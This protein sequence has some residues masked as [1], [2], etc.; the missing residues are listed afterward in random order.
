M[1]ASW[2]LSGPASLWHVWPHWVRLGVCVCDKCPGTHPNAVV[3]VLQCCSAAPNRPKERTWWLRHTQT[4]TRA[5]YNRIGSNFDR[6]WCL[7][8]R[9]AC[10]DRSANDSPEDLLTGRLRTWHF[11]II[12]I[13]WIRIKNIGR[14]IELHIQYTYEY[15]GYERFDKLLSEWIAWGS[16]KMSL[17]YS[18]SRIF[19]ISFR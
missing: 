13:R 3:V 15:I 4:H 7:R 12:N 11:I 19:P 10:G 5:S 16:V 6:F 8:F 18:P 17:N 1:R 9:S 2:L 14:C